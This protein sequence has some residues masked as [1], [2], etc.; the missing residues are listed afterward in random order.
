VKARTVVADFDGLPWSKPR[1]LRRF[2]VEQR[3]NLGHLADAFGG[4][5]WESLLDPV[6]QAGGLKEGSRLCDLLRCIVGDP[7]RPL[8][9]IPPAVLAWDDGIAAKIAARIYDER[10]FSPVRMG[11]LAD[12]LEEAGCTLAELLGHLRGPG[13]HGRGCFALDA[14]LVNE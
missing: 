4:G 13:L 2:F 8:P 11:V 1:T 7:F 10:D 12:A 5:G 9:P 14:I 6:G 3:D